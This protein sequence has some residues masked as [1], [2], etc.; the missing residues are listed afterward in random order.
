MKKAWGLALSVYLLLASGCARIDDS[1]ATSQIIISTD[2]DG[3]TGPDSPS[4]KEFIQKL[5]S[6]YFH[7][8]VWVSENPNDSDSPKIQIFY[9]GNK[10]T[11]QTPVVFFNGGPTSNSRGDFQVLRKTQLEHSEYAAIPFVFI[12]QRGTGCST[13]FPR[14][15]GLAELPRLALYGSE[16]I[17]SDAEVIRKKL[18]GNRPWKIF[19]QSYG[20]MIVHRY[21]TQAPESVESA[22]SHGFALTKDALAT[23]T[24]RIASQKRVVQSYLAK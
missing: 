7:D 21:V 3:N 10:N 18:L 22:S 8:F 2:V 14:I 17:V 20:G 5:P 11:S 9:Y 15:T 24:A 6:D 16:G 19:G 4:C 12:D 23:L 13:P 1:P